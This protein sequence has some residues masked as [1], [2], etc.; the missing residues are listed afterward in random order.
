MKLEKISRTLLLKC[1][2]AA[3]I[4]ILF[5]WVHRV[6]KFSRVDPDR[7]YHFA[8]S[9]EMVNSGKLFLRELPQV[10]GL[11]WNR[12]FAEKEFLF[13]QFTALGY[14]LAGDAGVGWAAL[15]LALGGPLVFYFFASGQAGVAS[16]FL[17][18]L[19][20]FANPLLFQRLLLIRPHV[21]AIACFTAMLASALRR[22][23]TALAVSIF[24]FAL[25]Y[26][27]FY[28]PVLVLAAVLSAAYFT[29]SEAEAGAPERYWDLAP[30]GLAGLVAGILVNPYFPANLVFGLQIAQIPGLMAGKL[31]AIG[32]GAELYPISSDVFLVN[33]SLPLVIFLL[34]IWQMSQGR[35]QKGAFR[36]SSLFLVQLS[37]VCLVMSFQSRRGA[38]Y[39][40]PVSAFLALELWQAFRKEWGK[41]GRYLGLA[42][43]TL[44]L[45]H[46]LWHDSRYLR[47]SQ[48]Q[49]AEA[50]L[51]AARALPADSE[52]KV[53]NCEWDSTPYLF[54]SRPKVRFLDILDPSLLYFANESAHKAREELK[55]AQVGDPY[56]LIRNAFKAD[57]LFCHHPDVISQVERDPRF[58]RIYPENIESIANENTVFVYELRPKPLDDYAKD[59]EVSFIPAR[60]HDYRSLSPADAEKKRLPVKLTFTSYLDL[61]YVFKPRLKEVKDDEPL[62]A[63]V[64]PKDPAALAGSTF[65]SLGGGRNLRVWK[66]GQPWF[67]SG[68][69]YSQASMHQQVLSL[70]NGL[71]G[72]DRLEF[73]VCSARHA[74]FW[75]FSLLGLTEAKFRELCTWK[76]ASNSSTKP[77]FAFPYERISRSCL[78]EFAQPAIPFGL[79]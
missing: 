65:L 18:T 47:F 77:P 66:N 23:K 57:Y 56:G 60:G 61:S 64:V 36:Y 43:A 26:H 71:K 69:A 35:R 5:A 68:M 34:A 52:A 48:N 76:Q 74:G 53:F 79:R 42:A 67:G 24:L 21:L 70:H 16:G 55:R 14:R 50:S 28:I 8:L 62:C 17:I 15:I 3:V 9:R 31:R 33:F 1:L 44:L 6:E 37:L 38:E 4:I 75:G 10:E 12:F 40:F 27:A 20:F 54:Y 59:Y 45:V 11:G 78:G 72:T 22:N 49:L 25:S 41:W 46:S 2:G 7:Y 19:I 29:R 73:V 32:F 63:L 30:A 13:H 58:R 39:L 51:E